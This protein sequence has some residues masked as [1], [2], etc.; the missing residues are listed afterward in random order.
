MGNSE[1]IST[2]VAQEIHEA[3]EGKLLYQYKKRDWPKKIKLEIKPLVLEAVESSEAF[4][5][6]SYK[7][8]IP[9]PTANFKTRWKFFWTGKLA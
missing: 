6:A 5:H 7:N 3:I 8:H 9:V 4:V 2:K 1:L